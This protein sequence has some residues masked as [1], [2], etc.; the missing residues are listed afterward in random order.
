MEY[1][2][3]YMD[4]DLTHKSVAMNMCLTNLEEMGKNAVISQVTKLLKSSSAEQ[5][6]KIYKLIESAHSHSTSL[7]LQWLHWT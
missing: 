6:G 5:Y 7:L 3:A 4:Y 2:T 1:I